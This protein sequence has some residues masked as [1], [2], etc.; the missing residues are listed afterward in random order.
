MNG[1][2]ISIMTL[3]CPREGVL[4]IK[5][6]RSRFSY[7]APTLILIWS[8]FSNIA[9]LFVIHYPLSTVNIEDANLF[10]QICSFMLPFL[11]WV[12]ALYYVTC[13]FSGEVMLRE[14]YAAT[15]YA[16]L[17]FALFTLPIALFT[18]VLDIS[19]AGLIN[20]LTVIV[21]V[22]V[23]ILVLIGI[24]E[25]NTYTI[26]RTM[27]VTLVS[28]GAVLFIAVILVLLYVLGAKLFDFLGEI[29][30]EYRLLLFD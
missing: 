22:W 7:F 5:K 1:Y 27:L 6:D 12:M 18:N 2:Q 19:S 21:R 15:C 25:M 28:L 14:V 17:P 29:F 8:L 4:A 13:I 3:F 23:V 16:L 11:I 24:R 10:Q 26:P 20:S 9:R 30:K